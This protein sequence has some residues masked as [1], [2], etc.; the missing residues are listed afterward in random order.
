MEL[1]HFSSD[2]HT[3]AIHP[4]P[5]NCRLPLLLRSYFPRPPSMSSSMSAPSA[6]SSTTSDLITSVVTAFSN[7]GPVQHLIAT[8]SPAAVTLDLSSSTGSSIPTLE[9][10]LGYQPNAAAALIFC[11]L[12]LIAALVLLV[13]TFRTRTWFVLIGVLTALMLAGGFAL[14]YLTTQH[15][16]IDLGPY[17]GSTLL[18]LV[19]PNGLAALNYAALARMIRV[20][21]IAQERSTRPSVWIP[22]FTDGLGR[23]IPTRI[24]RTFILSDVLCIAL[25][26]AGSIMAGSTDPGQISEG[27]SLIVAGFSLQFIFF[28]I[29]AL[30]VFHLYLQHQSFKREGAKLEL[31][32]RSLY[33]TSRLDGAFLC[34]VL[35][36][37]TITLRNIYR[38][39][40]AEN[41][42]VSSKEVY[43]YLFDAVLILLCFVFYSTLHFG[44]FLPH[45]APLSRANG[46]QDQTQAV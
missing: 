7:T 20:F 17:V 35:T 3:T 1:R 12:F 9:Q 28:T 43:T 37:T 42:S 26:F 11:F 31:Q 22:Y 38:M 45:S 15:T 36:M 24:S 25:Q 34:I 18:I 30:L 23:M 46:M 16:Q 39:V 21:L 32:D 33:P 44:Y 6:I 10:L 41:A 14:R 2:I 8:S 13:L 40:E 4:S 29:Y 5:L 27:H 19:S